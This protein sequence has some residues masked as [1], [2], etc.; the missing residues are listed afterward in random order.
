MGKQSHTA[1]LPVLLSLLILVSCTG[2]GAGAKHGESQAF[3][4][5]STPEEQGV[6]SAILTK[7]L[8]YI[9]AQKKDLH[10]ILVIQN[11]PIVLEEYYPPYNISDQ[12]GKSKDWVKFILDR[13]VVA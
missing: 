13:S 6:D 8:E 1:F 4:K 9:K 7:I 11:G 10:A 2:I 3:W 5:S 12:M